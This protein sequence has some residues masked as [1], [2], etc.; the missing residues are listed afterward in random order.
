MNKKLL[1]M[2]TSIA[3][4]KLIN[5]PEFNDKGF[6]HFSFIIYNGKIIALGMNRKGENPPQYGYRKDSKI[7]AEVDAWRKARG[8]LLGDAFEIINIRLNRKAEFRM[9]K[10][11][12]NCQILLQ[13]LG[14]NWFYFSTD[15]TGEFKRV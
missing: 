3:R 11:C 2:A 5:H 14:C 10:P 12:K 13:A 4:E 7:H 9:S 6:M 15:V 1:I 8:L